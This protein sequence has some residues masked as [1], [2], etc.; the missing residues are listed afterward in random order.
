[1]WALPNWHCYAVLVT[2]SFTVGTHSEPLLPVRCLRSLQVVANKRKLVL[3]PR[4]FSKLWNFRRI[5]QNSLFFR[6]NNWS[7]LSSTFYTLF[8]FWFYDLN[9]KHHQRDPGST[10][11]L[12]DPLVQE[13]V[14]YSGC[15]ICMSPM[16]ECTD[17]T[18]ISL[19]IFSDHFWNNRLRI[20]TVTN[21]CTCGRSWYGPCVVAGVGVSPV[22][23][24]TCSSPHWANT[25]EGQSLSWRILDL[26]LIWGGQ[27]ASYGITSFVAPSLINQ[28]KGVLKITP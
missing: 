2:R 19:E 5:C 21:R 23:L 17:C 20:T 7:G 12:V 9:Q 14:C 15:G 18:S 28:E 24:G 25:P 26:A 3:L 22:R 1:M 10:S 8:L 13:C 6:A 11:V 27:A 4:L 16:F